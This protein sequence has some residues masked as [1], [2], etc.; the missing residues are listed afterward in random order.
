M[1]EQIR[2]DRAVEELS[3][4]ALAE[5]HG[6]HRRTVRQALE[7]AVPPP[8][9]APENRPAPALGAFCEVIDEWLRADVEVPRKQRHS[10]RR[11]WQRLVAEHVGILGGAIEDGIVRAVAR[12]VVHESAHRE[13]AAQRRHAI[14]HLEVIALHG[15]G[16]QVERNCQGFTVG[17]HELHAHDRQSHGQ[18]DGE[19]GPAPGFCIVRSRALHAD[20][21]GPDDAHA[22]AEA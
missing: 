18:A 21:R 8:R 20:N 16:D 2:R 19:L 10:A 5:R 3:I 11:V 13:A 22:D 17:R 4:R 1:F 7:S 9:K 14:A 15:L 6:V 12:L